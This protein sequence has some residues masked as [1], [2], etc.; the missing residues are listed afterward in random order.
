ME[1]LIQKYLK[2]EATQEEKDKLLGILFRG[3]NGILV[4][5]REIKQMRRIDKNGR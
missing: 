3:V 1:E 5:L 4:E 2:G